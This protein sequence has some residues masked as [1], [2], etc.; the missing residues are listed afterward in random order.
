MES[1][2]GPNVVSVWF[3]LLSQVL[4]YSDNFIVNNTTVQL[5]LR[6]SGTA[7]KAGAASLAF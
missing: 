1:A 5:Y 7:E 3:V 2:D 4:F 6:F